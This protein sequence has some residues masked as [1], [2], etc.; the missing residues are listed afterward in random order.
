MSTSKEYLSFVLEQLSDVEGITCRQMMGEYILYMHGKIA[1]YVCDDR[2]LVKPVESAVRLMPNA[3]FEPPYTG[4]KEMLLVENVDD[5]AFL[6]ALFDAIYSE[7]PAQ[8]KRR[9]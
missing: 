1:A 8:K 5:R 4:A 3:L 2:L 7:L 9:K 6:K